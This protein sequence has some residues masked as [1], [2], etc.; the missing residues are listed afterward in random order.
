[1]K[2][3]KV[4]FRVIFPVKNYKA[5]RQSLRNP[6]LMC[7][8]NVLRLCSQSRCGRSEISSSRK[9]SQVIKV[10]KTISSTNTDNRNL[11]FF[12]F[13]NPRYFS[14]TPADKFSRCKPQPDFF[15]GR[16]DR[17]RSVND[18]S[19]D[20]DA[21]ITSDR[22]WSRIS[23]IGFAQHKSASLD[24]VQAFPNHGQDWTGGHVS[25]FAEKLPMVQISKQ[26]SNF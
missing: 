22:P 17:V 8:G 18:V 7:V 16:L 1:M 5:C 14:R 10:C 3:N 24:S 25:D 15:F 9:H 2:L 21:E 11:I 20:V 23:G 13:V 4:K 12:V 6:D 26:H 19:S